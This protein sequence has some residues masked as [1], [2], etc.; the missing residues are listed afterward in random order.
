[1][2]DWRLFRIIGGRPRLFTGLA[3]AVCSYFCLASVPHVATRV[4]VAWDIGAV[5]YLGLTAVLFARSDHTRIARDAEQQEEGEWTIFA[6]TLIGSAMSFAAIFI[7]T[8][9]D[10]HQ[11]HRSAYLTFVI[12]TLALSWLTT[13][14]TFAYRYAHEYYEKTADGSFQKGLEFPHEENPDYLDFVYY[15]FVLGMTFQVADVNITGRGLR[16]LATLHGMISFL[17]NTILLALSVN[18]AASLL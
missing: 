2:L 14:V 13:Q 6:L 12:S 18:I 7:F 8:N 9:H 1:M 15:S 4:V 5:V 11:A 16:R 17:F 3:L 10:A